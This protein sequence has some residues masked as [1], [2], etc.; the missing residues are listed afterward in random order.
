MYVI[1]GSQA[2]LFTR[3]LE[4]AAIFYGLPV[5]LKSKRAQQN[6]GEIESR[7]GTH[8]VPVLQTPENWLIADTTPLIA[9]LD[10]RYPERRLFPDGLLGLLTHLVEDFFD[11]WVSRVMVHYRWHYPDSAAF[12]SQIIAEGDPNAAAAILKWGPRACRAT[13]TETVAQQKAAEAE[14][15]RCLEAAEKQ[16]AETRYLMGDRP[17]AVDCIFLGGLRAHINFDPDPKK[18]LTAF[19]KVVAWAEGGADT[20]D[21][22]GDLAPFPH[23][24]GFTQHVLAEMP[25]TYLPFMMANARAQE[26][27]DK[28]FAADIYGETVSYLSRSYPEQARKMIVE[29]LD[30]SLTAAERETAA[31]W[32]RDIGLSAFFD[33]ANYSK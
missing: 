2:S 24:T 20:W 5:E 9:L 30:N 17:T 18:I 23:S 1:Y 33:T 11:E 31:A 15:I 19:P 28:A 16:L 8:Q 26:N 12:V 7:A 13:G 27:G 29:R 22:T 14:Y 6:I 10:G 3:K 32:L 4:A 25:T 21:G